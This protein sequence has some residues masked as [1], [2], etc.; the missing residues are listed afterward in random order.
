MYEKV[1]ATDTGRLRTMPFLNHLSNFAY[2]ML[3]FF[4]LVIMALSFTTD[5]LKLIVLKILTPMQV[6]KDTKN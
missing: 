4:L 3:H 5:V 2:A 1:A 6:T